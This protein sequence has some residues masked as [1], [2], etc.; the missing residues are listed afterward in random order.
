MNIQ[1]TKTFLKSTIYFILKTVP[2]C[3]YHRDYKDTDRKQH[4]C[5]VIEKRGKSLHDIICKG[6]V[7]GQE[8]VTIQFYGIELAKAIKQMHKETFIHSNI[9]PRNIV[10]V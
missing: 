10:H 7:T 4:K 6:R 9:Q 2:I 5:V 8:L 3:R 1:K